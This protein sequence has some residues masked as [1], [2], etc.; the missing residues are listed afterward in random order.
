MTTM[1][2]F[3]HARAE[4]GRRQWAWLAAAG[5]AGGAGVWATHFISMLAFDPGL[6]TGYE[7]VG[8]VA[9]LLL[10]VAGVT[11]ALVAAAHA[12][13]RLAAPLGGLTLGTSI[14]AMHGTGMQAFRTAGELGWRPD[15]LVAAVMLGVAFSAFALDVALRGRRSLARDVAAAALF[16]LAIVCLHF[17]SMAAVTIM[18]DGALKAPSNA[19]PR[20]AMAL[21]VGGLAGLIMLGAVATLGLE[22][23][24]QRRSRRRLRGII[25][26][27]PD[28]LAYF[29][30][31]D[32]FQL[33]NGTY[34][35]A[36]IPFGLRPVLGR[37][38]AECI[39]DP[40][41]KTGVFS[42]SAEPGWAQARLAQRFAGDNCREQASPDGRWYRVMECG[43][44][45]GGRVVS[46]VEI[47]ALKQAAEDLAVARDAAE[48][49]NRAKSAFLANMSHEIRTPLNGVLGVADAL[50]LSGLT[51]AQAELVEIIQGSGATL[52]RLL[53]DI[54]DLARV[55]SGAL[56][57]VQEPFQLADA[58]RDVSQ[59]CRPHAI[60]KGVAFDVGIARE[61]EGWVTGDVTR[62]KQIVTNL[63]ANAVKFTAEGRVSLAVE[64]AGAGEF[65]IAVGDTG[66]GFDGETQARLFGRFQQ[67]DGSITRQFGG[68]GLGLSIVRELVALIGGRVDVES[69]LGAGSKFSVTLPLREAEAPREATHEAVGAP[70]AERAMRVL[71]ADDNPNNRRLL[72]VLLGQLGAEV[73]TCVNGEEAVEAWRS[74]G[75]DVVLM[76][77]QM[78]VLDGLAATRRIRELEARSPLA[79]TPI[80]MVSANAMPEHIAAGA[81]AGADGHLSKPL[82]AE[83][84]FA[85]LAA[86]EPGEHRAAAA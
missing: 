83:R 49:A 16:V 3:G 19:M 63:V 37:T 10:A 41:A 50:A 79:R 30:A 40:A 81:E 12:P 65:R 72:E 5:V 53:C 67:G 25:E 74:G 11:S 9:S 85:A 26:A 15:Y 60:A 27:M 80:L 43:T 7:P 28:G 59:L 18:P 34:E 39:V 71:V 45:D 69:V 42:G 36:L 54:L 77:M 86:L 4:T 33:W 8:T 13:R 14:A 51:A 64:R 68:S 17:I 47:T 75:F 58:I 29:D 52:N 55:E 31:E 46:V 76:D 44:G 20:T 6:P 73:V 21:A 66:P 82:S 1:R 84:L 48:A 57:L 70:V 38:Y 2:L 56:Q 61:A 22:A 62:F 23:R 35:A 78:P 32:R 24:N